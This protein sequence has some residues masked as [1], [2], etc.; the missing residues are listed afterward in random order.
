MGKTTSK[1][2]ILLKDLAHS[3]CFPTCDSNKQH[4]CYTTAT[5]INTIEEKQYGL[6]KNASSTYNVQEDDYFLISNKSHALTM[7]ADSDSGYVSKFEVYEG[8]TRDTVEKG[9]RGNP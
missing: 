1:N 6:A 3:E 7:R 8:K 9:L 2:P 5:I 4:R